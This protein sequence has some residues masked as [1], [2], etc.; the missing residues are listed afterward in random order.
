MNEVGHWKRSISL[1]G[2]FLGEHGGRA[3]LLGT[4]KE[5]ASKTL[6]MGVYFH[7]DSVLENMGWTLF[8]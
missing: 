2:S 7:R 3:P 6:E 4:L 1:C 8:S 5:M